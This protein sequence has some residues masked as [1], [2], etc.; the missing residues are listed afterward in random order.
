MISGVEEVGYGRPA[1]NALARAIGAAKGGRALAPVTVVVSSN[2]VG[3]SARWLL[4]SGALG[5]AGVANVSFLTPLRLAQL[6]GAEQMLDRQ[7]LTNPVLS[8]AVRRALAT[9][10]GPFAAVA[11]HPATEAAL[12]GLHRELATLEPAGRAA[13]AG[14]DVAAAA[15]MRLHD[16]VVA[17]LHGFHDEAELARAA[18][19]RPGLGLALEPFGQFIWYLPAPVPGPLTFLLSILFGVAPTRVIMGLTGNDGADQAVRRVVRLAGAGPFVPTTEPEGP[20][21]LPS[22]AR[23]VSVS[24]PDEEVRWVVRQMLSL[25]CSG[26]PADRMAVF[27]PVVHPYLG[28]LRQHLAAAAIPANGPASQPLA[29]SAVGRTLLGALALPSQLWRR[30]RV[31]AVLSGGPLRDGQAPVPAVAWDRHSRDAGIVAGLDDW[32][33]KLARYHQ[34]LQADGQA[35]VAAGDPARAQRRSNATASAAALS[36]YVQMLAA[37]IKAVQVTPTWAEKSHAALRLVEALLGRAEQWRDWPVQELDAAEAVQTAVARLA[38]LDPVDPQPT[39]EAF[40]QA[41]VGELDRG[42]GRQGRFGEGVLFGPL[43]AAVGL[44]LDAVFLLGGIEGLCPA[45]RRLDSLLSEG[46]RAAA[47]GE[48]ASADD[49]RLDQHRA[50]LAALAAAPPGAAIALVPRGDLRRGRR[51]QP[52]RFVL[53]GL[54]AHAGRLVAVTEFD[55]LGPPLVEVVASHASAVLGAGHHGTVGDRDVVELTAAK[56]GGVVPHTHPLAALTGA[57]FLAQHLRDGAA[58]TAFD[59]N[60][61]GQVISTTSEPVPLT[62]T[63]LEAF[64]QCGFRYLLG[65]VL[66]LRERDDPARVVQLSPMDRGSALHEVLERWSREALAHGV[67]SPHQRWNPQQRARLMEIA[68]EVFDELERRGRTGRAVL[69]Q[70]DRERL[71]AQLQRFVDQDDGYRAAKLARP[72]AVELSFGMDGE[73]PL[74][75]NLHNGRALAFRGRADRVDRIGDRN[76]VVVDYKTGRADAYQDLNGD[77]ATNAFAGGTMLQLGLYAEAARQHLGVDQVESYYWVLSGLTGATLRGYQW[78]DELREQFL[79]VLGHIVEGIEGGLFPMVP[80]GW[81]TFRSGYENCRY[82]EFDAVC[83]RD[84]GES[85][86]VKLADPQLRSRLALVLVGE[87]QP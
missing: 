55:E 3:L 51:T 60:L 14:H 28:L 82:C 21:P 85:A 72:V 37:L 69:W 16:L 84:R 7:A 57:G 42:H 65:P 54:S 56:A 74:E 25:M 22:P 29:N 41:L 18:A 32:H 5:L 67:P 10:P 31:L 9:N 49:R 78:T 50:W 17:R 8:A 36:E 2:F 44:D 26:V 15:A 62:A 63:R 46:A 1:S 70:L 23:V 13:V 27:Y 66:G 86:E 4:G 12:V 35:A 64:A 38:E 47:G 43:S 11:D 68:G 20:P 73:R 30:D 6:L 79:E 34:Q 58:F 48:L 19:D 87:G 52:S 39:A 53:D 24:D 75:L 77:S 33:R 80:G 61:A 59:G 45:P 83:P 76:A 71:L 40:R 81:N